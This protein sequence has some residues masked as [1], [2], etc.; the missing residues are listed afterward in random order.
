MREMLPILIVLGLLLI[1][2]FAVAVGLVVWLSGTPQQIVGAVLV[3]EIDPEA[4]IDPRAVDMETLVAAIDRRINSPWSPVA[5]VRSLGDRRVEIRVFGDDRR[6][7]DQIQRLLA[8]AGTL[9][10]RIL[11][12]PA[13]HQKLIEQARQQED[14]QVRNEVGD[15]LAW[16]VPI[17]EGRETSVVVDETTERRT[18]QVDGRQRYEVL[19][20]AD[21]FDV[22]GQYLRQAT[23][24]MDQRG[25]LYV[26]FQLTP[27]G[28]RLFG[29]LTGANLPN[30]VT[31]T[32]R[33]LGIILNG[34]LCTAPTIQSTIHDRGQ[35]TGVFTRQ[36]V[37][38]LAGVLTA[39]PLPVAI[40]LVEERSG[41]PKP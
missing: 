34:C 6:V 39:G 29:G 18:K 38:D 22:T 23:P 13:D 36:E 28:G 19:V 40:R 7:V 27:E 14:Q 15:V 5:D 21:S 26:N 20:V 32:A 41:E 17:E 1:L 25:Q 8:Q 9:E 12:N 10:F 3:Y 31:G 16:W 33:K 35:I 37:E 4:A 24:G 2:A 11:A 30:P